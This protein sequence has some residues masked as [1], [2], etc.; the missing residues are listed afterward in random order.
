MTILFAAVR[1]DPAQY[2]P[3]ITSIILKLLVAAPDNNMVMMQRR[4]IPERRRIAN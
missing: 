4:K 2:A 1:F 3:S